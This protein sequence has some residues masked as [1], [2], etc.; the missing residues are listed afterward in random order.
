MTR[1]RTFTRLA[2]WSGLCV[3]ALVWA[4]N[5]QLSQLLPYSDCTRRIHFLTIASLAGTIVACLAGLV[6]WLVIRTDG[7]SFGSSRVFRFV[8]TL[9]ALSAAVFAFALVLQAIASLVLT[10]CE[11]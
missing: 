9:S 11:R 4:L 6:S 8:G 3:T 2:A 1:S 7:A 10:G 5:V